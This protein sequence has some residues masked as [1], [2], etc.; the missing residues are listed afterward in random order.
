VTSPY[1]DLPEGWEIHYK[2]YEERF[3]NAYF[4]QDWYEKRLLGGWYVTLIN[5]VAFKDPGRVGYASGIGETEKEAVADCFK[6]VEWLE[7]H[8]AMR[9]EIEAVRRKHG[10]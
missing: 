7:R 6:R 8:L 1:L 2:K 9:K 3:T 10:F 5:P 4:I